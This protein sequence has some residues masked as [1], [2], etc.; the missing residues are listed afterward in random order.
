MPSASHGDINNLVVDLMTYQAFVAGLTHI[1][2]MMAG[3]GLTFQECLL[4][5]LAETCDSEFAF[6]AIHNPA[7]GAL[8]P[9]ASYPTPTPVALPERLESP[10]LQSVVARE[11]SDMVSSDA[12]PQRVLVPGIR[13]ALLVPYRHRGAQCV[14][15]IC[16][17]A[18][19]SF[20]RPGLGVPYTSHEVKMVQALL[21]LRPI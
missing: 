13:T 9:F 16:N 6:A 17:R 18:P 21:E 1:P 8:R 2:E 11:R 15:C 20:A 19:D 3:E 5:V 12:D 7:D 14:V 4:R 10:I